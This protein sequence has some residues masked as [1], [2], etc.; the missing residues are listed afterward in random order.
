MR[1]A[2]SSAEGE[3]ALLGRLRALCAARLPSYMVP[4]HLAIVDAVPLSPNGKVDRSRLPAPATAPGASASAAAAAD[5]A[6][7]SATALRLREAWA[8]VLG[9]DDESVRPSD[10]FFR[11]GGDSLNSLRLAAEAN[12]R[13]LKLTIKMIFEHPTLAELALELPD[14]VALHGGMCAAADAPP[15]FEVHHAPDD[16]GAPFPLIG[17][18]RAYFVGLH[19]DGINPQIYF[20]WEWKG[21]CDAGRLQAALNAYVGRHPAWRAIVTPDG[22][23][24]V[25]PSVPSYQIAEGDA[26]AAAR[27]SLREA[28]SGDGPRPDT[29]PLF[30]CRLTH[31][32]AGGGRSVVHLCVSLFIMDGISDLT[33]RRQ[34]SALYDDIEAPLPTPQLLYKDYCLSLEGLNG[35]AGLGASAEYQASRAFWWQRV[36]E[37]PPPPQLPLAAA[38]GE[39]PRATGR[40]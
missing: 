23:M 7:L 32:A 6:V 22:M 19:I 38:D 37:L 5:G 18:T 36:R 17:I 4:R 8:A 16:G 13:G 24:R 25:L 2:G 34:L 12:R 35:S 1:T 30:D 21:R 39:A 26:D 29:W 40:L 11:V 9:V 28:M 33:L 10:N 14:A 15:L 3:A 31:D 20:E 27:L